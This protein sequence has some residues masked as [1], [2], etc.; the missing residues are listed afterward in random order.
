MS[1]K[2]PRKPPIDKRDVLGRLEHAQAAHLLVHVRRWIP[3]ADRL[4][5]FV[6]GIGADWVALQRL[7]DRITF[8]GWYLIR[9]KDIQAVSIDPEPDSF[10]V[11]ALQARDM[12][13]PSAPE[14]NLEDAVGAIT[15]SAGLAT[16]VS[17]FDEFD[18]PDVC[19]IGALVSVDADRLR[20]LEVNAHGGWARKPRAFDPAD[21]TRLDF[22]GGYEEALLLVAGPPPSV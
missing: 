6:V 2:K 22:G 12:W 19:W 10:E 1:R 3:H 9:R 14:V 15:S 21:V 20:L 17:V 11:R 5:G 13:P 7:S 8:D 18:R 16:M 4:E